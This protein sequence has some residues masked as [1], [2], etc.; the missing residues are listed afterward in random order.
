MTRSLIELLD[1][2]ADRQTDKVAYR[3]LRDGELDEEGLSY[4]E[5]EERS[6]AIG[7]RLQERMPV[8]ERV[9]LIFPAGLEFVCGFFACLRAGM[10]AV[11]VYPPDP[12]RAER[13]FGRL[14]HIIDDCRPKAILSDGVYF[15]NREQLCSWC[16]ELAPLAWIAS[17][18]VGSGSADQ[19]KSWSPK[20]ESIALIQ[21]TS[22]STASPKGVVLEHQQILANQRLLLSRWRIGTGDIVCAW[23]PH[24]HDMGLLGVLI[25]SLHRGVEAVLMSPLHF[26]QQPLRWLRAISRYRATVSGSPS[27]GYELCVRRMR[28]QK[29][30]E[31]VGGEIDL[32]CWKV[33]FNGAEPVRADVLEEFSRTLAPYG[34]RREAFLPCYGLAEATLLVSSPHSLSGPTI[35]SFDREELE[36]GQARAVDGE[37]TQRRP[38]VSC[39]PCADLAYGHEVLIVDP[40][41][42]TPC[43]EAS[44]GE[45]WVRGPSIARRYWGQSEEQAQQCFSASTSD[46]RGGFL[47]TGDLGFFSAGELFVTGRLKDL[48][49][50]CGRNVY[51][52]DVEL[53]AQSSHPALRAGGGAAISVVCGDDE[54]V[55]LVQEVSAQKD[56]HFDKVIEAIRLAVTRELQ[57]QLNAVALVPPKS[58]PKTPSG[59]I[60]RRTVAAFYNS[61]C[62]RTLAVWQDGQMT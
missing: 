32:S 52:Q 58:I 18:A 3:F 56:L 21:Y 6:R 31:I 48:I 34:F 5:L 17:D 9:L 13:S 25:H 29:M 43:K 59:K 30:P 35:T 60:Q 39:G 24:Y 2:Q 54:K 10:V 1:A 50:V 57:L 22:G 38:L 40:E 51:P 41:T 19:C 15:N 36:R 27:F 12:M 16:P 14:R 55:M 28:A 23:L 4:G 26:L 11:P 37:A 7:A 47:R 46:G 8:G 42:C 44:V 49:I 61:S 45:I 20:G 62:L 53:V 33:A